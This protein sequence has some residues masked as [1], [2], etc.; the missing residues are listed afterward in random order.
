MNKYIRVGNIESREP[1]YLNNPPKNDKNIDI[2]VWHPNPYYGRESDFDW[3]NEGY[4][5]VKD[6]PIVRYSP[7]CF[8]NPEQCMSVASFEFDPHEPCYE[9][10]H[11][12]FRPFELSEKDY[13]DYLYVIRQVYK[14][15]KI[16]L[17]EE[18]ESGLIYAE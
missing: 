1:T 14:A 16:E 2:V 10:K 13:T 4:A 12:C 15:L 17:S 3:D 11:V 5:Y 7:D 8:K 6:S 18:I 9:L